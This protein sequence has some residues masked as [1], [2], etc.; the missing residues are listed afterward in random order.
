MVLTVVFPK[1]NCVY[2]ER[3]TPI[4]LCMIYNVN[5]KQTRSMVGGGADP[6]FFPQKTF[7]LNLLIKNFKKMEFLPPPHF[8]ESI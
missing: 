4:N 2:G 6:H 5:T 7:L 8:S 3:V 1:L